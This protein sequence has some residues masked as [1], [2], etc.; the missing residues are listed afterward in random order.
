MDWLWG[1]C[2]LTLGWAIL[3]TLLYTQITILAVTLY[4]HRAM[5]H[6]ACDLN[7]GLSHFFRFWLWL[8]TSMLTNQWVAIHRYHHAKVESS[9]DPHSPQ[10]YGIW[11]LIF[12]GAWLY[13]QAARQADVIEQYS[14]GTPNDWIERRLYQP[15][16]SL[17][18]VLMLLFNVICF[19]WVGLLIWGLQ[20]IW[21]PLH[22][23]GIIN[24]IGHYWGY[25]NFESRDCSRNILPW[26]V[27]IGGEE[28]HNNHHA[29]P[30][31]ARFSVRWYEFDV[32]YSVLKLLAWV[33]LARIKRLPPVFSEKSLT[34]CQNKIDLWKCLMANRLSMLDH[35]Y[36]QVLAPTY[37]IQLSKTR[38][39]AGNQLKLIGRWLRQSRSILTKEDD[40]SLSLVLTQS[41]PLMK[42]KAYYDQLEQI[43]FGRKKNHQE[44]LA[45]LKS[46]CQEARASGVESLQLY[47]AWLERCCF[48][49]H[50]ALG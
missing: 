6:R 41:K 22:A 49:T 9:L 11:T 15:Y 17:G 34:S 23:A 36:N 13:T 35:Y 44:M 50:I 46:W 8:T 45:A 10:V 25:R 42:A 43:C 32:G 33:G 2:P 5:A 12:K 16:Q 38:G 27:W 20:M 21:I 1:A 29:F 48:S 28:L 39:L 31:S 3:V 7:I 47:A 19:G 26:G 4:L 18:I 24:G 30:D 37:R 14:Q 40:Q